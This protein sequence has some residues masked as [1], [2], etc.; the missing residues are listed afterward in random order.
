MRIC[1]TTCV[2]AKLHVNIYNHMWTKIITCKHLKSHT[3]GNKH[4]R[5]VVV[6]CVFLYLDADLFYIMCTCEIT[7]EQLKSHA[8]KNNY[9]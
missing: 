1:F 3:N 5:T 4:I 9:I 6:R 8:V 2:F 7:C